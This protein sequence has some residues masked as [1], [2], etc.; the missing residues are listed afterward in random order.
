MLPGNCEGE[1]YS[2]GTR[3]KEPPQFGTAQS[4]AITRVQQFVQR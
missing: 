2:A 3:M 4:I 1:Q